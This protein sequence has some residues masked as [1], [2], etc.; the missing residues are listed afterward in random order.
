[1]AFECEVLADG[2]EAGEKSLGPLWPAKSSHAPLAFTGGLM[3]VLGTVVHAGTGLHE[4]VPHVRKLRDLGLRC[5]V[6]AQ[7]VGDDL[8]WCL[9]AGGKHALKEALCCALVAASLD[10]NVEFGAMLIDGTPQQMGFPAQR[11]EHFVQMPGRSRLAAGT[12][13]A[14]RKARAELV[15]PAPDRFVADEHS[16]AAIASSTSRKLTPKRK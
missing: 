4:H 7:S 3:A 13:G 5:R 1:V 14:M 15:A 9:W 12:L 8:A 11:H 2:P 16:A 6:A 10:Q